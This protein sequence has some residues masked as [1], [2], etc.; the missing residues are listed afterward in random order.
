MRVSDELLKRLTQELT[1]SNTLAIVLAGSHARGTATYYSDVDIMRYVRILPPENE[2]YRLRYEGETLISISTTSIIAERKKLA[3]PENAIWAVPGLRQARILL[4]HEG[5][6][7]ALQVEAGAFIWGPEMQQL[8]DDYASE[9]LVGLAEEA[10]KIMGGLLKRDD[11]L[12]LYGAFG[13][14]MGLLGIMATHRAIF[15]PSENDYFTVAIETIGIDSAWSYYFQ[16]TLGHEG[17]TP[18]MRGVAALG[19]YMKTVDLLRP[20]LRV[21]HARIVDKTWAIIAASGYHLHEEEDD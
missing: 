20:I 6:F 21:E 8:A 16:A 2:R 12:T 10:H 7:A 3:R 14:S 17:A 5:L 1:D 19:L 18:R 11:N 4:D 9:Q 13:L 15:I